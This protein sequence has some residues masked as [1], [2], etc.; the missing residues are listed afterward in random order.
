MHR[1]IN[2]RNILFLCD[3]NAQPSQVSE[4]AAK[5]LAPLKTRIFSAGIKPGQMPAAVIKTINEIGVPIADQKSKHFAEDQS[6]KLI[7]P[8]ALAMNN[9]ATCQDA[10]RSKAGRSL[11]SLRAG[12]PM[13]KTST[14]RA[15]QAMSLKNRFSPSSWITGVISLKR[16]KVT[17]S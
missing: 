11:T 17:V 14:G 6:T 10:P 3:N 8:S 7:W 9:A 1:A 4:A 16:S 5:H 15:G 2:E 12:R 13:A